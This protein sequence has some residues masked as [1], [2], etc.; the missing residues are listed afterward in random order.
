MVDDR[1]GVTLPGPPT[2]PGLTAQVLPPWLSY[3]PVATATYTELVTHTRVIYYPS[4]T[5][6]PTQS[7]ITTTEVKTSTQFSIHYVPLLYDGPSPPPPLGTLFTTA[8]QASVHSQGQGQPTQNPQP[9]GSPGQGQAPEHGGVGNGNGTGNGN[10]SGNGA[11]GTSTG[12]GAGQGKGNGS[13]SGNGQDGN[14]A[15]PAGSDP[16][17]FTPNGNASVQPAVFTESITGVIPT[18]SAEAITEGQHAASGVTVFSGASVPYQTASVTVIAGS[19]YTL[20]TEPSGSTFT[21]DTGL[22]TAPPSSATS[23][24]GTAIISS[25]QPQSSPTSAS[26]AGSVSADGLPGSKMLSRGQIAGIAIGVLVLL[27]LLVLLAFC[28]ARRRRKRAAYT[29]RDR[30]MSVARLYAEKEPEG[31]MAAGQAGPASGGRNGFFRRFGRAG[32]KGLYAALG[33]ATTGSGRLTAAAVRGG[34]GSLGSCEW[35]E[36]Q[37]TDRSNNSGFHIVGGV[38]SHERHGHG[39]GHSAADPFADGVHNIPH[40]SNGNGGGSK[41]ARPTS[42]TGRIAAAGVA[43][44]VGVGALASALGRKASRRKPVPTY[45]YE[46]V[47]ERDHDD[48]DPDAQPISDEVAE[49]HGLMDDAGEHHYGRHSLPEMAYA[50]NPYSAGTFR[51]PYDP[52]LA[53]DAGAA[54]G[55]AMLYGIYQQQWTGSNGSGSDHHRPI[56]GDNWT[57]SAHSH[58]SSAAHMGSVNDSPVSSRNSRSNTSLPPPPRAPRGL[59]NVAPAAPEDNASLPQF[60]GRF[61]SGD[62]SELAGLA[63]KGDSESGYSQDKHTSAAATAGASAAGGFALGQLAAGHRDSSG[64]TYSRG[65]YPKD[66]SNGAH[67]GFAS[68]GT[69]HSRF[70]SSNTP[71]LGP[72]A[73]RPSAGKS[74]APGSAEGHGRLATIA[75]VGEFGERSSMTSPSGPA[76]SSSNPRTL[77]MHTQSMQPTQTD[78]HDRTHD[79]EF[80]RPSRDTFGPTG[81][82]RSGEE[83][84]VS[85]AVGFF[86][87]LAAGW[88]TLTGSAPQSSQT[89]RKSLPE[90]RSQQASVH[91]MSNGDRSGSLHQ[92]GS[93]VSHESGGSAALVA[94]PLPVLDGTQSSSGSNARSGYLGSSSEAAVSRSGSASRS[95]Q[96]SSSRGSAAHQRSLRSYLSDGDGSISTG[97]ASYSPSGPTRGAGRNS[98]LTR[99][100]LQP[101]HYSLESDA[102][103]S[104]ATAGESSEHGSMGS[105]SSK[106]RPR[107]NSVDNTRLSNVYEGHEEANDAFADC[108]HGHYPSRS[109]GDAVTRQATRE[110]E[111]SASVLLGGADTTS[112]RPRLLSGPRG[113]SV[114]TARMVAPA[115]STSV[116]SPSLREIGGQ[117]AQASSSTSSTWRPSPRVATASERAQQAQETLGAH[118]RTARSDVTQGSG[119]RLRFAN[120][121]ADPEN[122]VAGAADTAREAEAE[123]DRE[124]GGTGEHLAWPKFLRF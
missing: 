43:S 50:P 5:R 13:G 94:A 24:P 108:Q 35:E 95:A 23:I 101:D 74:S 41:S 121:D 88:R 103:S 72:N 25:N 34:R 58:N 77:S 109:L 9:T 48:F 62:I 84:A 14:G 40:A 70:L 69:R 61:G 11:G 15:Q 38:Q 27:V 64:S 47:A 59:Q 96:A 22:S 56:S 55:G 112:T 21:L 63:P 65:Y 10:D 102:T 107:S 42:F 123:E 66:S 54:A 2:G 85:G 17:P 16:T 92:T 53:A 28:C 117:Q 44:A 37:L 71:L 89:M 78:Q 115:L 4:G 97:A 30:Y 33:A 31:A 114:G 79:S 111:L 116:S 119:S 90:A 75:S 19:L 8:N 80:G 93:I 20:A 105:S 45:T 83:P 118:A 1:S 122:D 113:L 82:G 32:A 29:E 52:A 86:G 49:K 67:E 76:P 87:G 39:H 3:S 6:A 91:S 100:A 26:G 73:A 36:D 60:E 99:S 106:K 81:S 51:G 120:P 7:L 18:A 57:S 98:G 124:H 110:A 68:D 12:S 104:R 46:D